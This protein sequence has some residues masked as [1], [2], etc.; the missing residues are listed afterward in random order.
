M[1]HR[2]VGRV[3]RQARRAVIASGG[4]PVGIRTLLAW[5]FPRVTEPKAWHRTSVHRAARRFLV[6]VG[7]V[8]RANLWG[9]N[10]E[11]ARLIRGDLINQ[12]SGDRLLFM[13]PCYTFISG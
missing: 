8:G 12:I 11:L 13:R 4:R 3:E 2:K 5:C 10:A 1:R 9:P 6:V 7:K